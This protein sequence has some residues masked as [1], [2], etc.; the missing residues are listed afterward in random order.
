MTDISA[1]IVRLK[2]PD[3]SLVFDFDFT[4]LLKSGE[5]LTGTPT[6]TCDDDGITISGEVV[7]D[8]TVTTLEGRTIDEGKAVLARISGGEDG[9]TY[10]VTAECDTSEGN[11]RA[12]VGRIKVSAT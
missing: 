12:G 3:E 10:N 7:N 2:H 11:T 5:T 4:R 9:T 1:P 8:D 6:V